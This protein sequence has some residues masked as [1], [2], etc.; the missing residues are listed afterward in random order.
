MGNALEQRGY[1]GQ[2]NGSRPK[3]EQ[4]ETP[5]VVESKSQADNGVRSHTKIE[6]MITAQTAHTTKQMVAKEIL[7]LVAES[8]D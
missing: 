5:T 3:L 6:A 4:T 8:L 1:R 2:N 7:T